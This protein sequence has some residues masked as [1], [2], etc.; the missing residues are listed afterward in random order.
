MP[1]LY[2]SD[3][4]LNKGAHLTNSHGLENFY[5]GEICL[6]L[7]RI[8]SEGSAGGSKWIDLDEVVAEVNAETNQTP[9][10]VTGDGIAVFNGSEEP[11]TAKP[12]DF[13]IEED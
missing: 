2:S 6:R 13:W 10:F 5:V 12:G 4:G 1:L 9:Q 11:L 3:S 7:V 8:M